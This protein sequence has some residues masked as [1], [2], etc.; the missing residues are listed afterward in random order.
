M[1]ASPAAKPLLFVALL[2]LCVTTAVAQEQDTTAAQAADMSAVQPSVAQ[3]AIYQRPFIGSAAGVSV[4]GYAEVNTNY[5]VEDGIK[6]GFSLEMRRFNIFV[7]SGISRRITFFSELEFEHGTEEIALETAILDVEINPSFVLRGGIVLPPLGR[8]NQEHDSPLWEFVERPLVSTEIIGATLHE[9]GF[10]AYGKL[11]PGPVTLTYDLYATNG[12]GDGVLVNEEGRTHL[13]SGQREE[14]F[15][16]DNNGSPAFSGRLAA[17][18]ALVGEFGVS[19]Y[20]ARYNTFEIEGDP[21]DD[22]RR[23][24]VFAVDY[25]TE[26]AGIE[27]RGEAAYALID[28]PDHMDDVFGERQWGAHLDIIA[29]VWKP[30]VFGLQSV[31]NLNLRLEAVDFNV[32]TFD[33]TGQRIGD[34]VYAVVPGVSFRPTPSTVFRANY[35]RHWNYDLVGNAPAKVGGIQVGFASYF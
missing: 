27:L 4:G 35:R 11:Y 31:L 18:Y 2:F 12:I 32:G 6:E 9:V 28:V 1:N 29:P 15:E 33:T 24:S 13:P 7:Y 14:Q 30:H 3:D 23:A 26:V 25:L 8:F 10:G 21:V 5:F 17:R 22:P 16:E 19:F 34:E 20:T